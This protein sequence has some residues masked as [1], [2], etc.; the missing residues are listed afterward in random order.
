MHNGGIAGFK[1]IK[2]RLHSLL[3]DEIYETIE[4]T[5][6]PAKLNVTGTTDSETAFAIFLNCL[7]D[8]HSQQTPHQMAQSLQQAISIIIST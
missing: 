2:R 4:G 6:P 5:T 3:S 1:K 8:P 7:P